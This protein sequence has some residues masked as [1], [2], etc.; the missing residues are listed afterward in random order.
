M[1]LVEISVAPVVVK[2]FLN[3]FIVDIIIEKN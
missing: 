2:I 1:V 3:A